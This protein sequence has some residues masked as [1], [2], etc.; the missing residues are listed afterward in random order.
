MFGV[1]MLGGMAGVWITS[2]VVAAV[3]M[4]V[5]ALLAFWFCPSA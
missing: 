4:A 2:Y 1:S 3:M 5:V